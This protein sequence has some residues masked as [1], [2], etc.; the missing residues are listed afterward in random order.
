MLRAQ[1]SNGPRMLT[2][3][4]E[5]FL[6]D[7]RLVLWRNQNMPMTN[8]CRQ[9]WEQLGAL[10]VCIVLN[11]RSSAQERQHWR[12]LL[13]KWAA[14]E[15]CPPEDPDFRTLP[16]VS[17]LFEFCVF[18]VIDFIIFLCDFKIFCSITREIGIEVIEI[19]I[20]IAITEIENVID[21]EVTETNGIGI[22]TGQIEMT[23]I[24]NCNL[25]LLVSNLYF[26]L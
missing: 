13:Q 1:D 22:G 20:G 15:V 12:T 18:C 19:E 17:L 3:M 16:P 23:E 6:S 5:Q 26:Y 4:T 21:I 8:K 10:W 11:P 24:G 9:L 14:V 25:C 2:L 7:P